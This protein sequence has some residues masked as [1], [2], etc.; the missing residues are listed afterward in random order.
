MASA[1]W[2]C[3][4]SEDEIEFLLESAIPE[5]EKNVLSKVCFY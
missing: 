3:E 1:S 2:F 4:V 5:K